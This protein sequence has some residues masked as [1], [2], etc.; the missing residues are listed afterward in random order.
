MAPNAS[1][2]GRAWQEPGARLYR[3]S[4][5]HSEIEPHPNARLLDQFFGALALGEAAAAGMFYAADARISVPAL[6]L[7]DLGADAARRLWRLLLEDASDLHVQYAV[8]HADEH[9]G[10]VV[11]IARYTWRPTGRIVTQRLHGR[12]QIRA[13]RIT[14]ETEQ[15]S[16]W[17]CARMALGWRGALGGWS[18]L[19]RIR[20]CLLLSQRLTRR[21]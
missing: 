3:R 4:I 6:E 17:A 10:E 11:W 12:F 8:V 1:D 18:P 7:R 13:G 16:L 9:G 15:F 21:G 14:A 20:I 2:P 5:L 19:L